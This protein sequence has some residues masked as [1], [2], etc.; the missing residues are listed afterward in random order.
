MKHSQAIKEGLLFYG[1]DDFMCHVLSKMSRQVGSKIT[2]EQVSELKKLIS[3]RMGG[4]YTLNCHL[5]TVSETYSAF[6]EA[7]I[8]RGWEQP[9]PFAMRV[10]F[11]ND[12]IVELEEKG[13]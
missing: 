4:K 2:D 9:E 3:E 7:D 13:L 1:K 5:R 12:F 10:A 6:H 11:W 8:S